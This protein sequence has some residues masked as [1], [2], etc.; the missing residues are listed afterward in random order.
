MS[1]TR[2]LGE[3][4]LW[5]D[6]LCIVQDDAKSKHSEIASMDRIYGGAVVTMLV[7]SG[8]TVD[9]ALPGVRPGTL[10]RRQ[11]VERVQDIQ[12][13]KRLP[14]IMEKVD[15]SVWNTRAWTYQERIL[16]RRK[17]FLTDAQYSFKCEHTDI[18][19]T[20]DAQGCVHRLSDDARGPDGKVVVRW[21]DR[22]TGDADVAVPYR[23]V[24]TVVYS[25]IVTEF[26][27]RKLSYLVD[28]LNAF[29]GVA[30]RLFVLFQ[31]E[32]LFG[33]PA[34][35]LDIALLWQPKEPL[36][37][38][39][40]PYTRQPMFPSWS[41]AG[42]VGGVTCE[43]G[44]RRMLGDFEV[45]TTSLIEDAVSR[46]Q[47][48][49]QYRGPATHSW[50]LINWRGSSFWEYDG[51]DSFYYAHPLPTLSGDSEYAVATK[52]VRG[53]NCLVISASVAKMEVSG[54]EV[55]GISL[56]S[57]AYGEPDKRRRL[58]AL[59]LCLSDGS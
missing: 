4:Y 53:H 6:S 57:S 23:S 54:R 35:E 51:K 36:E 46:L 17:L 32:F 43:Y 40:D 3:G 8:A 50:K 58:H 44:G 34:S 47:S 28:V 56:L 15:K 9:A 52:T 41:W 39:I 59:S 30:G 5:V 49:E 20:E 45:L 22:S 1:L 31:D 26:T 12:L 55:N 21:F 37:R 7:S 16:S 27:S 19:L 10:Q 33:L 14:G 24:N 25:T 42:W 13:V 29:Q 2:S 48:M 18:E 11:H 38:R